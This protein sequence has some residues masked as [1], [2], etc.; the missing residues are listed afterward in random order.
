MRFREKNLR[1][2]QRHA[3][4][5]EVFS[6]PAIAI[7]LQESAAEHDGNAAAFVLALNCLA[8]VFESTF[9][10]FPHGTRLGAN[11][12]HLETV[13]EAVEHINLTVDGAVRTGSP[14]A[15][16]IVLSIGMPTTMTARRTVFTCGTQWTAALDQALEPEAGGILGCL[17]GATL[18]A[19][20]VLLHALDLAGASYKP[21]PSFCFNL[22]DY[23]STPHA[24]S[25]PE[26]TSIPLA[27]LVGVGA[28]G[29]ACLYALA[30]LP[31]LA[32]EINLIDNEL[33]DEG[34]LNR[35][36]LMRRSDLER[37]K[38]KVGTNALSARGL[39]VLP[40]EMTYD[41]FAIESPEAVD[42]LITPVDSEEGRCTLAKYLP[43]RVINAATG[44]TTV[45]ISTH[46][47]ADGKACLHCLYL[48]KANA[49]SRAEII[50]DDTGL[51]AVDVEDRIAA[52]APLEA[53]VVASIESHRGVPA[54]TW[55][56]FAGKAMLS[57]YDAAICGEA[58][59]NLPTDTVIAPLSFISCAAGILLAVELL[60]LGNPDLTHYA[61]DNYLRLDTLKP[62]NSAF[63]HVKRQERTGSCICHDPDYVDIYTS[64]HPQS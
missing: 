36:V 26:I 58:A 21:M 64:K 16:D 47:F 11:P 3:I 29:S 39:S 37:P 53:H 1:F 6:R 35:Y 52:N 51:S 8:R 50:A 54:G 27:H 61:L 48:P 62:P 28:V 23:G 12:W 55:E 5:P 44:G 32:G 18:G 19:A 49:K 45:T 56:Q 34:N 17:Y 13:D 63:R 31:R 43:R 38:V 14:S 15:P 46:G 59:L 20:Q 60:K 4:A 41:R 2:A 22:L 9:A 30:H 25:R 40:H 42:L 10:V 7:E 24:G 57:F 33:V